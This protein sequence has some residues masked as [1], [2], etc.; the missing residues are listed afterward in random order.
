MPD[1]ALRTREQAL[2]WT[3]G[4]TRRFEEVA[5]SL[6][7]TE[8]RAPIRLAGWHRGHVLT[9]VARNADALRNL[10]V[11]ARTG[12][13]T[14]MYATPEQRGRDI[15]AGAGRPA[16]DIVDDLLHADAALADA[17]TSLPEEA[18]HA[19]VRSARGRDI[20]ASDVAWLRAREVW[21]HAV[22][23]MAGVRMADLPDEF[24]AALFAE[25]VD[26]L[27]GRYTGPP[28]LVVALDGT[29]QL[30]P[31]RGDAVEVV[32]PAVELLGW[33]IGRDFQDVR[34]Q[35]GALPPLPA[36]L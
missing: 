15:E 18:W 24:V 21:I 19:T 22:D 34:A 20:P 7:P 11:W 23:L 25:V 12:A 28:V 17:I 14:P 16:A 27:A 2:A 33:L 9:H 3:A 10:L 30:L 8:V 36:W 32:G 1:V 5:R 29:N 26:A 13:E 6:D 35:T 4:G 31:G